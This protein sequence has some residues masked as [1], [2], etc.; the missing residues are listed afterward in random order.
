MNA[1]LQLW[2]PDDPGTAYLPAIPAYIER[3]RQTLA[4]MEYVEDVDEAARRAAKLV[5]FGKLAEWPVA[6]IN[7]A[8]LLRAEALE[9]LSV[10]VDEGQA[11]GEI[12]ASHRP[13]KLSQARTLTDLGIDRRRVAEGRKIRD[14]G[15]LD[16]A[17]ERLKRSPDKPLVFSTL[18]ASAW[19]RRA[20][21]ARMQRNA[22][23]RA[24]S[25]V[26]LPEHALYVCSCADLALHVE[27]G[28][29]DVIVTDP[30]YPRKFLSCWSELADF[31]AHAL[32]PGGLL[33]A[34]S[35][36]TYLLDVLDSLRERLEYHWVLAYTWNDAG[37]VRQFPRKAHSRW[38]P[39]LVFVNGEYGGSTWF[40]D[41]VKSPE[42][43]T[44]ILH[45]WGQSE[46]GMADIVERFSAPN[47]I[48]CDPFLGSGTTAVI[49]LA[50]GR[51][52]VG[53]DVDAECVETTRRRLLGR[54][55]TP[56]AR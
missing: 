43:E 32:K 52:F 2:Q 11:R 8:Q 47:D 25:A 54:R 44:G 12:A 20:K 14:S 22:E 29:V 27:P 7:E 38:K 45:K 21:L 51:R 42:S 53:C 46:Q 26:E 36:L 40:G 33:V 34:M 28:S 49:A 55:L 1:E 48:V 35:G 37:A 39:V 31:A 16:I 56:M 50:N 30:P 19:K 10:L 24:R 18:L 9:R 3:A 15:A 5:E 41:V 6:I 4:V 13:A 23:A 17:R